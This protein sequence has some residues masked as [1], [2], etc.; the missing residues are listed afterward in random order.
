ML[1]HNE[2]KTKTRFTGQITC[3]V[4]TTRYT[5]HNDQSHHYSV[6]KWPR[7]SLLFAFLAAVSTRSQPAHKAAVTLASTYKGAILTYCNIAGVK[8][9][10]ELAR[11]TQQEGGE[12]VLWSCR[13]Q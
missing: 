10:L 1:R 13:Q 8:G 6:S 7:V 4:S 11:D 2:R 12:R 5:V 9:P 3:D